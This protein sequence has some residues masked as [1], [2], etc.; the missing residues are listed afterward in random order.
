MKRSDLILRKF[1]WILLVTFPLLLTACSSHPRP[2]KEAPPPLGYENYDSITLD[3]TEISSD[4]FKGT[5][6]WPYPCVYIVSYALGE[7]YCVGDRVE[8]Y[9]SDLREI[10]RTNE[11]SEW[12]AQVDAVY[13]EPSSFE[14]EPNVAYKP[15]IYLYPQQETKV[16]VQL[17]YKGT[18]THTW[19]L[20]QNGW[21]ITAQPD[22]TL[23]DAN[24]QS[25]PYL[26]WEGISDTAYDMSHGFCVKGSN[27][28]I[29]LQE[30]LS[31]L[32][33]NAAESAEF[34]E[35]WLPYLERNPY[36]LITFQGAPYLEGAELS[37]TPKPDT[38]IRVFM[39]F[40]PLQEPID[41]PPQDLISPERFGFTVVEWGGAVASIKY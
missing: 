40:A 33:L 24:G 7:G 35:F 29:F 23:I 27:S 6:P 25:Y 38:I 39:A 15:V 41:I 34:M 19:P 14:L 18:L 21:Q 28:E 11:S 1:A 12:T 16:S 20:Y 13:V 8:V 5:L 30:S 17:D 10:D 3:I 4:H 26:F 22:G 36:N 2:Q 9:Y 32:G 37:I 31:R